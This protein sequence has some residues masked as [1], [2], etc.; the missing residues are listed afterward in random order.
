VNIELS[1]RQLTAAASRLGVRIQP[2][3][4]ADGVVIDERDAV[5][6]V[7]TIQQKDDRSLDGTAARRLLGLYRPL[8]ELETAQL[9]TALNRVVQ[10]AH[11]ADQLRRGIIPGALSSRE[12]S[13]LYRRGFIR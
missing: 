12:V 3:A 1:I 6:L 11:R 2:T 9:T 13:D 10:S 5:A 8:D 4:A 7:R